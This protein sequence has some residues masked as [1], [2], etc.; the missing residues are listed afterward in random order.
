MLPMP[1]KAI[2]SIILLFMLSGC[3][4]YPYTMIED[5]QGVYYQDPAD[6][7]GADE[8][9]TYGYGSYAD[10]RYYP[11][12]SLDY[13]YLGAAYSSPWYGY[14]SPYFYPYYFSVW[15]SPWAWGPDYG[16]GRYSAWADPY[17]YHRYQRYHHDYPTH[18]V[19]EP[20][21]RHV[22]GPGASG[23]VNPSQV[24]ENREPGVRR[25]T[26]SSP[27]ITNSGPMTV[28]SPSDGKVKPSRAGPVR[29]TGIS[30]SVNPAARSSAVTP[31]VSAPTPPRSSSGPRLA[32]PQRPAI[33][34][35]GSAGRR[36]TNV[37]ARR[38]SSRRPVRD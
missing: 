18:R 23:P 38:S 33:N 28:V 9:V 37:E 36:S 30:A 15:Y 7:Y 12:W 16:Y 5:G 32:A 21:S 29:G 17:W 13:Y 31:A 24:R 27:G 11:W 25:T 3:V 20:G 14:Y 10:I 1:T 26:F 4:S 2:L 19:Q 22:A 6:V 35:S 8:Y 34:S